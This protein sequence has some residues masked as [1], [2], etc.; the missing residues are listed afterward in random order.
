MKK[1]YLIFFILSVTVPGIFFTFFFLQ[2]GFDFRLFFDRVIEDPLLV[3]LMID[4][5]LATVI[6]LIYVFWECKK[7]GLWQLFFITTLLLFLLGISAALSYFLFKR[8]EKK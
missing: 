2:N 1:V 6:F 8:E 3:Y 5:L 4:F 7:T